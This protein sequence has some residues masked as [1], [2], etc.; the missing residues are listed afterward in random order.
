MSHCRELASAG[1]ELGS[2]EQGK[3]RAPRPEKKPEVAALIPPGLKKIV[4]V[5]RQVPWETGWGRG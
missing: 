3:A 2:Q 4:P 5:I 1:L